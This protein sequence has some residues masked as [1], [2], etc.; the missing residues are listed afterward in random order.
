MAFS[1]VTAS[2]AARRSNSVH[3]SPRILRGGSPTTRNS[4][5]TWSA[6][7]AH[8]V[9]LGTYRQFRDSRQQIAELAGALAVLPESG[10]IEGVERK[11]QTKS[12]LAQ[13]NGKRSEVSFCF[14]PLSTSSLALD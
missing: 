6:S 12:K 2:T 4:S 5:K 1:L 7:C 11:R 9:L 8:C 14:R 13:E 10:H 3:G